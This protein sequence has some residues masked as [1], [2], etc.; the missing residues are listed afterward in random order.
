MPH[1][2]PMPVFAPVDMPELA[3]E[4]GEVSDA[5]VLVGMLE[6]VSDGRDEV[7]LV[8]NDEDE[9]EEIELGDVVIADEELELELLVGA[10]VDIVAPEEPRVTISVLN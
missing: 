3:F 8:D 10:E 1:P 9:D 7:E 2:M 5:T 4:A 6:D